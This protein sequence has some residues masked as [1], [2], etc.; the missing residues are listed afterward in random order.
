MTQTRLARS[1]QKLKTL[2][3]D[4][5][6]ELDEASRSH[7]RKVA[8]CTSA[9]PVEIL[10][11]MGFAVYFPEN[12]GAL[13]GAR[14]L[15]TPLIG[16]ANAQG[17]SPDICSYLTSDIGAYL[18]NETALGAAYG[19]RGIP[20]P[21]VLVYNTSQCREVQDWFSFYAR[22]FKVPSLGVFSP[23]KITELSRANIADVAGQLKDL[24]VQLSRVSGS[25]LDPE[26][27]KETVRLSSQASNLWKHFLETAKRKPSP[28][29][30]FDATIHMAP[31]VVMRG[32][33]R[34]C[35]YYR[36]L[37]KETEDLIVS[38]APA[39]AGERLRFYWEGMPNWGKL[40][41]FSDLFENLKACVVAST[42]CLS[43]VFE[44]LDCDNPFESLAQANLR[45]F[46]NRD[47]RYKEDYLAGITRDYQIDAILFH[48]AKTCPYNTNTRFGLPQRLQ[49]ERS[50]ASAVLYGDL[51]DLRC[52]SEEQSRTVVEALAEQIMAGRR[53]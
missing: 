2:M 32:G 26:R 53:V 24:A 20:K 43:W 31:I 48:E 3:K 30:F 9:G 52:F 47:E 11:A 13:L 14:R 4:Y 17:Y 25:P 27:L 5:Y 50:I 22:E 41:F 8:W 36:D 6:Q 49:A 46:I 7:S 35:D 18:G 44:E 51:C 28:I 1:T 39:V 45:V 42:Y 10:T 38:G 40:R 21:D 23:W 33:Q 15:A 12:H 29:T 37:V 19:V 16:K 34:A